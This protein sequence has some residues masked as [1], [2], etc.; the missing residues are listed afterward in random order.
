MHY[1]IYSREFAIAQIKAIAI[2]TYLFIHP[3]LLPISPHRQ[4]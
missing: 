3:F 2:Q 4:K 1:F